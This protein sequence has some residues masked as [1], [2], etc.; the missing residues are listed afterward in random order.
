MTAN[1]HVD[2]VI[3]NSTPPNS[4]VSSTALELPGSS[5]LPS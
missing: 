4:L 3:E 5:E 1:V 2:L